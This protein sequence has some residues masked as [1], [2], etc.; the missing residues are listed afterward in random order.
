[1]EVYGSRPQPE[2]H[3]SGPAV[4]TEFLVDCFD[5]LVSRGEN[6]DTTSQILAGS[7]AAFGNQWVNARNGNTGN[8][9]L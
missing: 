2:G 1:M 8:N 9:P 7:F 6:P 4:D 3:Q 5:E